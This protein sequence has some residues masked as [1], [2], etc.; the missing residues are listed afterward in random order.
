MLFYLIHHYFLAFFL[1]NQPTNG[2]MTVE[3]A[4]AFRPACVDAINF[5]VNLD[6][7]VFIVGCLAFSNGL[8]NITFT[9]GTILNDKLK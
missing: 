2:F 6:S 1:L 5:S 9:A 3:R 8:S 4:S 7:S